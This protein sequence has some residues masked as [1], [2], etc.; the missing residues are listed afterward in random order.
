MHIANVKSMAKISVR[1]V[2][3]GVGFRPFIYKLASRR[4]LKGWVC[5]TSGDVKI[6]VEGLKFES[7]LQSDC[8][9]LNNLVSAMIQE[10]KDIHCLRD[11]TRGGLASALNEI[12]ESSNVGVKIEEGNLPINDPVRAAC[13]FLG[14]DPLY[15][16]NEGKL[17]AVVTSR[18]AEK[19]VTVM[20]RNRYGA[21][22]RIIGEIVAD[23]PGK[24][25]MKTRLGTSRIIEM[26]TGELLPRIC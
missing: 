26:L 5:N 8:A 16:A 24:V 3:Q 19:M 17:V 13:E 18:D 11:P 12:A 15:I 6:E 1:G 14:F 10:S 22:S 20:R 7:V 21:Q 23:H 25:A 9:P 2:V 4:G